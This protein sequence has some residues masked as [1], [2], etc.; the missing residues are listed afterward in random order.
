MIVDFHSHILPAID[1]GAKDVNKSIEMLKMSRDRGVDCVVATPHCYPDSSAGVE[2]FIEKRT[3]AYEILKKEM[4]DDLPKVIQ[5]AEVHVST[6]LS[7]IRNIKQLC[8][9]NTDYMLIEMPV[10]PW[11]ERVVESIYK[12]TLRGITPI[13]AH[14]ERNLHQKQELLDL[15]YSFD[16]LIQINAEACGAGPCKRFVDRMMRNA[17][18][19]VVG[20]DMHN[21]TTRQPNMNKARKYITGRYGAECWEYLNNNSEK[22]LSG[23]S[24]SYRDF[25]PFGKK[26]F[27][28]KCLKY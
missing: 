1:D 13:I 14:A 25:K 16:I 23:Q 5:G 22:V 20:T 9:E 10:S 12:L 26:S 27:F 28:D 21:T 18:I 8:I 3:A 11:N 6:D 2:S 24:L 15:L 17:M 19:H 4:T 7:R